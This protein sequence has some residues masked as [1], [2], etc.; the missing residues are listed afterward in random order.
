MTAEFEE[1]LRVH[2]PYLKNFAK[3]LTK[4]PT[5]AED[6][7]QETLF[8]LLQHQEHFQPEKNFKAWAT[9]IMRNLFINDFRKK[10]RHATD[11]FDPLQMVVIEN[12]LGS[13]TNAAES[14]LY[15]QNLHRFVN[16]LEDSVKN[17]FVLY[18]HGFS[19]EE[20]SDLLEAD[21]NTLRG[22]VFQAR[23]LLRQRILLNSPG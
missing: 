11:S 4:N 10:T 1:A 7:T 9:T 14:E 16:D 18:L 15:L 20:I 17:P 2:Q 6:L 23:K 13:A 8:K 19:Y 5:I 12:Y 3:K 22:K 21:I